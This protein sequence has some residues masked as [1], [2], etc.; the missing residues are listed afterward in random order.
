MLI[1]NKANKKNKRKERECQLNYLETRRKF[2][3]NKFKDKTKNWSK[4]VNNYKNK[5][6]N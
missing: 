1:L 4:S 3:F 5:T 2:M 6:K